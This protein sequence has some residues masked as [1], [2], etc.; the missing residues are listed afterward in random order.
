MSRRPSR[1]D[2]R[3]RSCMRKPTYSASSSYS[4]RA[5]VASLAGFPSSGSYCVKEVTGSAAAQAAS[6]SRPSTRMAVAARATRTVG[7]SACPVAELAAGVCAARGAAQARA[8][9]RGAVRRMEEARGRVRPEAVRCESACWNFS[10]AHP[11]APDF[12]RGAVLTSRPG[13]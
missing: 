11:R 4:T 7:V 5:S 1:A 2:T 12:S 8:A 6:S 9:S 3:P 13:V 10:R